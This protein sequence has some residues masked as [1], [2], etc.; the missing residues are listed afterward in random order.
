MDFRKFNMTTNIDDETKIILKKIIKC[1]FCNGEII[2]DNSLVCIECND[3]YPINKDNGQIDLRLKRPKTILYKQ[4]INTDSNAFNTKNNKKGVY[5]F[6][7]GYKKKTDGFDFKNINT[8]NKKPVDRLYSWLPKNKKIAMDIGSAKDEKNKKYL[9]SAGYT[10]ISVDYDSPNAMILADA[11]ALPFHENTF[12]CITN[13]AVMEHIEFPFI[14]GQEFFRTLNADGRMLGV[15]A[16]LQQQHMSSW[17]HFTHY[18]VYSWLRNS[19]FNEKNIKIDAASKIYH[20][21][22]NTASLIGLPNWLKNIIIYPIYL[23]HR[24]LWK[25]FILK[26]GKNVEKIRHLQTTGAIHFIAD[27]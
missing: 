17:Y 1:P 11:H 6:K 27:K 14:A 15:V 21:I 26:T 22:F 10:Y 23:L 13:L 19:G 7:F 18:G 9:Q 2:W 4:I 16:F 8:T 5:G 20:G 25:I 3:E 12:D 24:L